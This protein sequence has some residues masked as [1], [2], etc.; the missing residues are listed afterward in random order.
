VLSGI[1]GWTFFSSTMAA[2][3]NAIVDGAGLTDKVWFPR[4][5]LAIVPC[6]SGLV[7][8]GISMLILVVFAPIL[9]A[10]LHLR[11]LLLVPACVLLVV[12]TAALSLVLSALQVYY[13]DV[14][15]IVTA[16]LT[17]WIYATPILY[18]KANVH[19]LGPWLDCNPMTG[20]VSLFHLAVVGD[21]EPWARAVGI[22]VGVTAA[23]LLASLEIHRR[24]DRLFVDLL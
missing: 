5:L 4:A 24:H 8:L 1:L 20:V 22:S 9:G 16:A 12:F 10:G 21:H 2:S 15:F 23:L 17:V 19:G 14:R 6:M 3:V 18:M 11:I 7:G 13:R